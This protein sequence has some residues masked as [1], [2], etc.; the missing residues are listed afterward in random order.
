MEVLFMQGLT[1]EHL[2]IKQVEVEVEVTVL[3]QMVL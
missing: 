3:A 2:H 1:V